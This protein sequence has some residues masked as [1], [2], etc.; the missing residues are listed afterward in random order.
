MSPLL[1]RNSTASAICRKM[2]KHTLLSLASMVQ[3]LFSQSLRF[4]FLHSCIWMYRYTLGELGWS[5]PTE[6]L[7]RS[8]L[9][10]VGLDGETDTV[11]S[12]EDLLPAC[13]SAVSLFAQ[14]LPTGGWFILGSS[15]L[16]ALSQPESSNTI[17]EEVR[18]LDPT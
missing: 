15:L 3:R 11:G 5:F 10:V 7:V 9:K 18:S 6:L 1:C 16:D 17:D 13:R 8:K 4:S 12:E 2:C 14:W